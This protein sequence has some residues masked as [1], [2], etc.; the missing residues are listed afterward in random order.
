MKILKRSTGPPKGKYKP[1][2]RCNNNTKAVALV[3][4]IVVCKGDKNVSL[5]NGTL[6]PE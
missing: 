5:T 2:E 1:R 6:I 3:V 4:D